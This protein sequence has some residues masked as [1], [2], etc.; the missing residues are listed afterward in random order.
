MLTKKKTHQFKRY[1]NKKDEKDLDLKNTK[2]FKK[3]FMSADI[4]KSAFNK[5]LLEAVKLETKLED[6]VVKLAFNPNF[7]IE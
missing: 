1:P 5:Y 3:E 7:T 2:N 6:V 4:Q